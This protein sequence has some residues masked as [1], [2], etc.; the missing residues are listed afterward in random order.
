MKFNFKG[1][2]FSTWLYFLGF[3]LSIMILLGLLLVLFIKPYYRNDRLK[4][5][6]AITE[7]MESLLLKEDLSEKDLELAARTVIGNNVCAI[8]YNENGKSIYYPPDSLGQLCM[9]DK[10]ITIG[11]K[12]FIINKDPGQFI[13]IIKNENPFSMTMTSPFTDIE[14]LLYGK[15]VKTNLANYYL[16]L[17]TPLE[18]VE[19]YIDFIL[20]QYAYFALIVIAIALILALFL[21]RNISSPIVRMKDEANKLAQGNYDVQFRTDSFSEIN[22]LAST[23]DDATEKLSKVNDLRK[24]LIANVSHDIK[25]PLTMIKAY[26]EMIKDISGEDPVKRDEHLNVII[27]ESDYLDRLVSDMSELSKLQ[28]GVIEVNR[29][30]FDLKKCVDNVVLL[31]SKAINEKNINLVMDLDDSVV[32]ADEIKISQ[33]IYNYLSNALKY[34]DDNSKIIIRSKA[35]EEKVRLEVIDNGSG[36]SEEALPYIWDR[37]YKVDKNFNRSVNSTGLGLAIAKAILEA[38]NAKYG[39]ESTVGEGSTF[40]FELSKDYDEED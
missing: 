19:S 2:R 34:S 5:V 35:D 30:N 33:V 15:Q 10:Q 4:T 37:Y 11:E 39:V 26:A 8:I 24:D 40:W 1:I 22:D 29:D 25:T 12:T 36:I 13:D 21:S 23:L 6:D 38:H 9:L 18:P 16:I 27:Q 28:S 14:M 31:L 32:Y 3:S 7:T 17:N 20:N